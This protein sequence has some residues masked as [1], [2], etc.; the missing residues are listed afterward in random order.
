MP[1]RTECVADVLDLFLDDTIGP[2]ERWQ[3]ALATIGALEEHNRSDFTGKAGQPDT[4]AEL[5]ARIRA[6]VADA[7]TQRATTTITHLEHLDP[8]PGSFVPL[9]SP[10]EEADGDAAPATPTVAD[11]SS[12]PAPP[13]A[14]ALEE[15]AAPADAGKLKLWCNSC[16][17]YTAAATKAGEGAMKTHTQGAHGR[18]ANRA[19]ELV[20]RAS[21]SGLLR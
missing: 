7:C 5:F 10:S 8:A 9:A 20:P 6:E 11:S 15:G 19:T 3:I 2:E 14:A 13:A 1:T 21:R 18:P 16:A 4:V 17:S 12:A